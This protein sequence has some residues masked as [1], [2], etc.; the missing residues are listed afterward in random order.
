[1]PSAGRRFSIALD[2]AG[3]DG[4]SER[5]LDYAGPVPDGRRPSAFRRFAGPASIGL[6]LIGLGSQAVLRAD[7]LPLRVDIAVLLSLVATAFVLPA[8]GVVVGL[9]GLAV[10]P[11]NTWTSALGVALGVISLVTMGIFLF[12]VF[13]R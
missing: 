4:M 6:A 2:G 10:R 5:M 1:M 8:A 11:Y 3:K 12:Q 7:V 9:C 13:D